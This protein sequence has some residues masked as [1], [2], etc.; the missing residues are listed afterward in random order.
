MPF[1]TGEETTTMRH[2][3]APTRPLT[4]AVLIAALSLP[5]TMAFPASAQTT[6]GAD[7]APAPAAPVAVP[8]P[9]PASTPAPAVTAEGA[10]ALA[11]HLDDRLRDYLRTITDGAKVELGG[12][13][14]A[15]VD[16]DHYAVSLPAVRF[17]GGAKNTHLEVAG[18]TMTIKPLADEE[19]ALTVKLPSSMTAMQKG[20]PAAT[21]TLGSQEISGVWSGAYENLLAV[22]ASLTDMRL[23]VNEEDMVLSI[24]A[25]NVTEELKRDAGGLGYSGPMAVALTDFRIEEDEDAILAVGG[26][27]WESIYTGLRMDRWVEMNRAVEAAAAKNA[28]PDPAKMLSL[29]EGMFGGMSSRVRIS[30]LTASD[31]DEDSDEETVVTLKRLGFQGGIE[32]FDKEKARVSFGYEVDGIGIDP[33]PVDDSMIPLGSELSLTLREIPSKRLLDVARSLVSPGAAPAA[34]PVLALMEIMGTAGLTLEIGKADVRMPLGGVSAAGVVRASAEA[35]MGGEGE[36]TIKLRGLDAMMA[37]LKPADGSKPDKD[38]RELLGGLTM[39]KTMGRPEP[40]AN[41]AT[42]MVYAIKLTPQGTLLL[43]GTDMAP[44]LGMQ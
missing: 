27:T 41:G 34:P 14:M 8:A 20:A 38:T 26:V 18:V 23:Q 17:D 30:D 16:S 24:G 44:L 19:F 1:A 13:T 6:G 10:T 22:N 42:D 4:A 9:A 35:A 32:D 28:E 7:V 40:G 15:V 12:P 11:K 39:L 25:L 31:Y 5:G 3:L 37:A 2:R 29:V 36:V 43:N 33:A 21:L